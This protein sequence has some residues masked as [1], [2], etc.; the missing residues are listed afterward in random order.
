MDPL[1]PV[2]MLPALEPPAPALAPPPGAPAPSSLHAGR[3]PRTA[4]IAAAG[5]PKLAFSLIVSL[6]GA[7]GED[8]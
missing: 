5:N 7:R 6:H 8:F 1:P 2:P 3:K 4:T